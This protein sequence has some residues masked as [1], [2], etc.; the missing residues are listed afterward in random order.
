MFTKNNQLH[1]F[2]LAGLQ[3]VV[4]TCLDIKVYFLVL[5]ILE[6]RSK[7]REGQYCIQI[8][9]S[10]VKYG[11]VAE[12]ELESPSSSFRGKIP[13][14]VKDQTKISKIGQ[15]SLFPQSPPLQSLVLILFC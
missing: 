7:R 11:Q 10:N 6:K 9:L 5:H 8:T 15:S 14:A 12:N 3:Q 1:N 2:N 13:G 4:Q